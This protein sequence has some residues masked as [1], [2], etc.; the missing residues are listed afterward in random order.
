[1]TT[2]ST[3]I[4]PKSASFQS[5]KAHNT[6]LAEDCAK[7]WLLPGEAGLRLHANGMWH[8]ANYCRVTASCA[9]LIRF[10]IP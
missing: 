8:G 6:S 7:R 3:L 5:N 4:D 9:C 2:L 10:A 1:M